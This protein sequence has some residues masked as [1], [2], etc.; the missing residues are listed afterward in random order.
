MKSRNYNLSFALSFCAALLMA[1]LGLIA[2]PKNVLAQSAS[3]TTPSAANV[4]R[5]LTLDD[6]IRAAV[7]RNYTVRSAHNAERSSD[8]E[9]TRAKD[10]MWQPTVSASGSWTY[11]YSLLPIADRQYYVP[12]TAVVPLPSGGDTVIVS[13]VFLHAPGQQFTT[14]AGSQTLNFGVT[15]RENLFNGGAD[16]ARINEAEASFGSAENSSKWT[17]QVTAF[18]V[19]NDY[20]NVLRTNELVDAARK[21]LDEAV[22]QLNLVRGQYDAGVVPIV[23]VYQQDAVV[24]TDSLSLIQAVNNYENAQTDL[25]FLLNVPPNEFS[26]YTFSV[27]GIDTSTS[28]ASRAA[29]DTSIESSRFNPAIDL[30][31]DILAEQQTI[32]AT[33]DQVDAT[34]AAL[35]PQLNAS[36]G[37]GGGGSNSSLGAI[38][39]A[40]AFNV[41][42]SLNVPIYDAMQNRLL[43][44][45]QE[46]A[47]ES[48]RLQLEQDVQQVRSDAA[49]AVN[50]LH[51]AREALDVSGAVLRSAE[52][53][54]RLAEEQLTVGSG[55]QVSVVVAEAALETARTNRVNAKY[56]WVLAQ[57]QLAYTLGQ[58]KY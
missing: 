19:T 33:Q 14:P 6:A 42:L 41:G 53:G 17:R 8:I 49:K 51:A 22:A 32:Q 30:R 45:E 2:G 50:N 7:V 38:H 47:V 16:A 5:N 55:T 15:A 9:V 12:Q 10:N 37:I 40:D 29:I 52:E 54:L 23:Q 18:N 46:I 43:I 36:V 21:T 13:G 31:S 44:D 57:R 25:L 4:P 27:Q 28:A 20:L 58:W 35:Y 11:D 34:R 48:Q 3:Q 1:G 39:I 26:S 24:G 56:N